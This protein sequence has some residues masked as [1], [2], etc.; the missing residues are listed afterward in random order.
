M[1]CV[2][3]RSLMGLLALSI[4]LFVEAKDSAELT[5]RVTRMAKIGRSFSPS[6][7]SDGKRIAFVSDLNG[8]PQIWVVPTQG[9]WPMLVTVGDDPVG[10]VIWSPTSDW[11]AYS[12]APGGGMNTQVYVVKADG[13]GQKRLTRGGK[14]TNQ[15]FDWTHDGKWLETRARIRAIHRRLMHTWWSPRAGQT[16]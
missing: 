14:E 15:L 5:A 12:L 10:Y 3:R 8:Q 16:T 11:L 2:V 9:G 1:N 6:F 13:S 7:S 4:A